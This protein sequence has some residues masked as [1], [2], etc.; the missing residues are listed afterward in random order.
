VSGVCD[1]CLTVL[2]AAMDA[3]RAAAH[4]QH[5]DVLTTVDLCSQECEEA[6]LD[7]VMMD[8]RVYGARLVR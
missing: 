5:S 3:A 1:R 4:D 2:I 8:A 7:L 6:A